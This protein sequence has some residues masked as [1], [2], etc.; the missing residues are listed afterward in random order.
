MKSFRLC[1]WTD[2]GA[3]IFFIVT[4]FAVWLGSSMYSQDINGLI[5]CY[6]MALPFF[7]NTLLSAV[8][9]GLGMLELCVIAEELG[10]SLAPTPFSSSIYLFAEFIKLYGTEDQKK[11]YL[12]EIASGEAIG[13]FALSEGNGTPKPH[14][15]N[16]T[17][18][19]GKLNGEKAPVNDGEVSDF[20]IVAANTDANKNNKSLSL[21]IVDAK[22][23]GVTSE[24][25][26]TIDPTRP[27]S[28]IILKNAEAE[29]LGNSGDGWE[30]IQKIFERAA[31]LFAFEQVGGSACTEALAS[32][33]EK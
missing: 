16:S 11:K 31:V 13:S 12:P 26:E 2:H 25:L 15:L 6:I 21:F 4:N 33:C 30:I 17:F 24:S 18:S 29:L 14:N 3:F 8:M 28:R 7:Q 20:I 27:S 19:D 32:A 1:V 22:Q 10:R 9:Y 5:S 23:D